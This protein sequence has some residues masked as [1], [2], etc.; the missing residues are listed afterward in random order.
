MFKYSLR[1]CLYGTILLGTATSALAAPSPTEV[2]DRYVVAANAGDMT[3]IRDLIAPDVERSDFV[4]C[5][6]E[7]DN[8]S[9]LLHYIETTVVAPEGHIR[10][11]RSQVAGE[12]V[13]ATLELRSTL[14][15]RVGVERI[16]GQD[17]VRISDGRIKAFHFIP[18][19]ADEPTAVFFGS[20]GI[21]PR[22]TAPTSRP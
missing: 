11:V 22:A 17:V 18:D 21:G 8:P 3:A 20:L 13:T 6:P 1:S 14:A 12:V 16:L 4:G 9:C 5:S 15:K 10:V 7:M 19:F 2:F